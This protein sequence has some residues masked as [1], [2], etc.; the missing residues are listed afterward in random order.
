MTPT[1]ILSFGDFQL[2]AANASLWRGNKKL[3]LMPKDFTLL[4]YLV[5]HA[6]QLVTKEDLLHV[7]WSETQVSVGVLK[8]SIERIRRILGDSAKTP[9]FIETVQRRGYRFIGKVV[10]SQHSVASSQEET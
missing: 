9:R 8:N 5:A 6:G 3:A 1:P 7:V 2:D 4:H 10:G